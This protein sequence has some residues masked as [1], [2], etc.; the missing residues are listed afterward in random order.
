MQTCCYQ[1]VIFY[2]SLRVKHFDIDLSKREM[3]GAKYFQQST[4][5]KSI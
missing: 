3:R 5:E 1:D 4:K 2:P